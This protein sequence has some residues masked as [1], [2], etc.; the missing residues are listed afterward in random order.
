MSIRH[1]DSEGNKIIARRE[2][3]TGDKRTLEDC[4]YGGEVGADGHDDHGKG[5]GQELENNIPGRPTG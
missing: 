1:T 4:V 2:E 3:R 5:E